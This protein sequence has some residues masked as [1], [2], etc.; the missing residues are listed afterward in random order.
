M[1]DPKQNRARRPI[2]DRAMV[3]FMRVFGRTPRITDLP[4]I[5]TEVVETLEGG[6]MPDDLM[7]RFRQAVRAMELE[8]DTD[9]SIVALD[10]KPKII[11]PLLRSFA[12]RG[13][14]S[15]AGWRRFTEA[16]SEMLRTIVADRDLFWTPRAIT[17]DGV[18]WIQLRN[19]SPKQQVVE[20]IRRDDPSLF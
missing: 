15:S 16:Y 3:Q 20:Q 2:S 17:T 6:P 13:M 19:S 7:T 5:Y 12:S 8:V 1:A 11:E 9:P 14:M 10:D 4:R 18:R